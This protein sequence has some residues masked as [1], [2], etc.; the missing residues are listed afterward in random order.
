MR[1]IAIYLYIWF[2][3]F[4]WLQW[5]LLLSVLVV[6]IF[7]WLRLWWLQDCSEHCCNQ[8]WKHW[9][10]ANWSLIWRSKYCIKHCC[11]QVWWRWKITY[12]RW[13]WQ[14]ENYNQHCYKHVWRHIFAWCASLHQG[15][16]TLDSCIVDLEMNKIQKWKSAI[17]R[18]HH[19]TH[20]TMISKVWW[21]LGMIL[22]PV[23]WT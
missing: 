21:P 13:F 23:T 14:L 12:W 7:H 19:V 4:Q 1:L 6:W 8:I 10:F 17:W 11:K 20:L 16:N 22:T 5:P 9:S 2:T 15:K 3:L 18:R